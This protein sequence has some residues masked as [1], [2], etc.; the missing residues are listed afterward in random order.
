MGE[1]RHAIEHEELL[2]HFQPKVGFKTGR[3]SGVEALVRWR[4]PQSGLRSPDDFIPLAE[5]TGLIKPLTSWVRNEALRQCDAWHQTGIDLTVAVNI[6]ASNLQ[7]PEFPDRVAK[8]LKAYRVTPAWLELEITESAIM[9]QPARA[10]ETI[11]RLS[12]MGILISIDDFGTGYSSLAYLKKLPV[13]SIKIDKSFVINMLVNE[14]DTVIVRSTIELGHNLGL[15][16]VAEGVENQATWDQ[17]KVLG[18]D[19][20]QGFLLS[21]PIPASELLQWLNESPWGLGINK[22]SVDFDP[23]PRP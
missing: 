18:C 8:L 4:H 16:V 7:D 11:T 13:S 14:N 22:T 6:S 5:Q 20:A 21:R 19:Y 17:L 15:K 10:I 23:Q 9:V 12:A 1:L 3:I 2:L